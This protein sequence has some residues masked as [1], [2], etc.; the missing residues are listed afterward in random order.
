MY[1]KPTKRRI[2]SWIC[3]VEHFRCFSGNRRTGAHGNDMRYGASAYKKPHTRRNKRKRLCTVFCKP[4]KRRISSGGKRYAL[5]GDI[6]PIKGW[7][8]N[9]FARGPGSRC[10][11]DIR[12]TWALFAPFT[13]LN[14]LW[15]SKI[16]VDFNRNIL[17]SINPFSYQNIVN[18]NFRHFAIKML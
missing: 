11:D 18:E 7:C 4:Y 12:T 1:P 16:P 9:R 10:R 2:L 3:A 8:Y 5:D 13:K 17:C 15:L 6:L 14:L